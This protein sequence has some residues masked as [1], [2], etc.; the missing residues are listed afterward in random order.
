MDSH[1]LLGSAPDPDANFFSYFDE[2]LNRKSKKPHHSSARLTTGPS[3]YNSTHSSPCRRASH[4][5]S[6]CERFIGDR[7]EGDETDRCPM[8]AVGT[9]PQSGGA[10][11]A[12]ERNGGGFSSGEQVTAGGDASNS[13]VRQR[14]S[15]EKP[16]SK[17]DARHSVLHYAEPGCLNKADIVALISGDV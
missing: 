7:T 12:V 3:D 5:D 6:F 9:R 10:V 17:L 11:G 14:T 16:K 2:V 1:K 15:D 8:L 4:T 13:W